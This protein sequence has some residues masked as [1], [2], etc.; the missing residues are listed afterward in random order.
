M[1]AA[2]VLIDSSQ[3]PEK[4]REQLLESLRSR[5]INHKFHYDSYKQAQKWLALHEA[6]SPARIDSDC[7]RIY[8]EAFRA[9]SRVA[10]ENVHV[11]GL[12]CGGGQ[13]EAKL[14]TLLRERGASLSYSPCDVSIALVL[15]AR[16]NA[17]DLISDDQCWPVVCDLAE[18]DDAGGLFQKSHAKRIVTF[19]G[20]IPNFEP[21]VIVPR[22]RSILSSDDLLLFSANLAPGENYEEGVRTILPQYNNALTKEWLITVLLDLGIERTDGEVVFGIEEVGRYRRVV[23]NFEFKKATEIRL[24]QE[25]NRFSSGEKI[26]LFFSYRYQP[27]HIVELLKEQGIAVLEQ[28]ITG[29]QEEGVFLCKL[30]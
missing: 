21:G 28:W 2:N 14:L 29:S 15:T 11:V 17:A 10:G 6:Y 1:S 9:A 13:K 8:Q 16:R 24:D 26:R 30:A 12:G 19:F 4:V 23:A 5:K 3:F 18:A 27:K 7:L 25:R 22:L 20:M